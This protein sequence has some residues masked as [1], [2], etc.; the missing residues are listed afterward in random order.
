M[1]MSQAHRNLDRNHAESFRF[2]GA[3]VLKS[4][5]RMFALLLLAI[6]FLSA[7]SLFAAGTISIVSAPTA[8]P[9]PAQT[10]EPVAFTV[11]ASDSENAALSYTWDFGDGSSGS[12]ES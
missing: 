1:M 11:S 8:L 2:G 4:T 12:G 6:S 10:S 7:H 5:R 3:V 9:N